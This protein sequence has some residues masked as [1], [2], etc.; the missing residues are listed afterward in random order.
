[1]TGH[2]PKG[3]AIKADLAASHLPAAPKA[4][5]AEIDLEPIRETWQHRS[6]DTQ[7]VIMSLIAAVEALRARVG[8]LEGD[9][10][11]AI[12]WQQFYMD[13]AEASEARC[14]ELAGALRDTGFEPTFDADGGH[15]EFRCLECGCHHDTS[16]TIQHDKDCRTGTAL[17]ATPAK[18]LE[19]AR[20]ERA[21]AIQLSN[22]T[23]APIYGH[24]GVTESSST[25]AYVVKVYF[26]NMSDA[27]RCSETI[28]A[29]DA[30]QGESGT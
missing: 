20:V 1:M 11:A 15:E 10:D 18:A 27:A 12:K 3:P 14:V 26:R 9:N 29:L 23:T 4:N 30:L 24:S 19:R 28:A 2:T 21:V 7:R 5:P 8:E 13:K 22:R 6:S 17:A 25:K 16:E